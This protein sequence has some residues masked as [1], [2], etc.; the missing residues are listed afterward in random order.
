MFEMVK[1]SLTEAG[2]VLV[3]TNT[4]SADSVAKLSVG[5]EVRGAHI[6][7]RMS[8]KSGPF[9]YSKSRIKMDNTFCIHILIIY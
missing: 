2:G 7:Y 6:Q 1:I 8:K 3:I 9:W 5:V 4:N